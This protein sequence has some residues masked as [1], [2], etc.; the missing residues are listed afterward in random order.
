MLKD[1]NLPVLNIL[2]GINPDR[3]GGEPGRGFGGGGGCRAR[4]GGARWVRG[5]G[6]EGVAEGT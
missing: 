2:V 5:R 4:G 1:F 6:G 3:W